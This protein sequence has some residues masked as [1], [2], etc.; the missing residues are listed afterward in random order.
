MLRACQ[1]SG[2]SAAAQTC[3]CGKLVLRPLRPCRRYSTSSSSGLTAGRIVGA[4][5]LFVG[6]GIGGT[7]LYAKWDSH[8]RESVEKTI[9]Y[10]DRLFEMVLGSAPYN[11]PLPKKPIQSGP[12]KISSVSEVMKESKQPSSQLQKQKGDTPASTTAP[13]EAAQIISAAGDTLSVPAPAVQHEESVKTDRPEIGG[14]KPTPVISEEAPSSPVRERPPEEVAARLAQQEKH[15]QVEI[16]SLAKSLE[17]AL[18][19]TASV[20]L[21]AIAAQNA[22][23]QAVNAHSSVLKAAMDDAE[24][25]GEKKSAQWRTVEGALKER[26]KAVDEAADALLKAKEELEKM[27][28]VIE[29]AKRK[30]VAG[31][32][33]HIIAA[34]GKLRDMIVGLDS[35]VQKVQAAQSE[36]KVVSQ[37]HELVVQARDDFRRELESIT[38]EVL[39]GWKGM[40]DKLSTDDLNSLIAH[41]HRRIDQ[42][43]REL[44]EQKATEKQH[45]ALALEKQKL[46]EKRAFD[47]AVAKALEHHRSEVQ[48]EQDRKVEE[49]RDAMENEMRTQLRRQAAA[50]TDHLRDVLRVQEQELKFEFEQDLSEKLSEQELEFRRL[51]QEQVDNFTLDINTA[52][53]RLRGIEQAVQS[54]AVA[55]EEARKAHQLWLSV[56][57]LKYSMKTSSADTP[58]VPLGAAVEAIRANCSDSE[59]AQALT[60]AIPPES[61][62]RGVYSEE[63]LRARFYTVQKQAR[64]VA[65]IDETRN[66][67]YQY[68]LS[69]LQSLL[70][71]PPQQLKPPA[72]LYPEDMSTFKLLSYASY[73]IEHGDLELAAK[74]VNQLKGESRRVAQDWLKEARMTLE[75]KQIVEILTAYAS[76]VGIGTTQVQPE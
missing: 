73:C 7:I 2:V 44:A 66:S 68:F 31:A 23:V 16:A 10:S 75:T 36:A 25:A 72:E 50:H 35:V 18:S 28:S 26:R 63:T 1:L 12:L 17:D 58:T 69:Y 62:T 40:T 64:R 71:F 45:I 46:E 60:A 22:A 9:P 55:E 29:N 27:K 30:E 49:V 39:S 8:F 14:G 76:A 5:L 15:E 67:L 48:A 32:K 3:L 53:A 11:V 6:G 33:P 20:T 59:F 51:S 56:E 43:N 34:E 41:A 70:L 61:L 74:F 37:Y 38:P 42:L 65:M 24:V 52:Y 47:S 19:Q 54:H 21:Q 13:T 57:A 4:G